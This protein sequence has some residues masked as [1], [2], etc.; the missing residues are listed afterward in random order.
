VPTVHSAQEILNCSAF[1]IVSARSD[2]FGMTTNVFI[3]VPSRAVSNVAAN[4]RSRNT[5]LF[6]P[7]QENVELQK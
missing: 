5:K 2:L 4:A 1:C 7:H 6:P 3:T